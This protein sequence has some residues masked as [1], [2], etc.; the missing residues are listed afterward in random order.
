M[1][2]RF[3]TL[4]ALFVFFLFTAFTLKS[5]GDTETVEGRVYRVTMS[6]E[7]KG[8]SG[9]PIEDVVSFK[10]GK[11]RSKTLRSEMGADAIE[12]ELTTDSIYKSDGEEID[13]IQFKGEITNKLDETVKL[14]GT[15]D[16]YGIEGFAELSKGGK[17]K[18]HFDFV[19]S[20]KEKKK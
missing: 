11:F 17:L 10:S 20:E 12:I 13:Y 14:E 4:S 9:K 5:D 19:G 2:S 3:F 6:E 1:Q 18:R 7:K 15:I 8:K 16:G